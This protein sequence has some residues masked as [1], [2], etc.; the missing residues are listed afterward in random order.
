[1]LW[2]NRWKSKIR[3]KKVF[4]TLGEKGHMASTEKTAKLVSV[5]SAELM[6]PEDPAETPAMAERK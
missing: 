5:F 1:M 2:K 4:K 3:R 6:G